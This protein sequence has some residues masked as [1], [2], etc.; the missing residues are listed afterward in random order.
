VRFGD[1]RRVPALHDRGEHREAC[2]IADAA[3]SP[4]ASPIGAHR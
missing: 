4:V 2:R 3:Y 1:F